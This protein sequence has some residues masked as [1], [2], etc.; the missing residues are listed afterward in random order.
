MATI[1]VRGVPT[2]DG[3]ELLAQIFQGT[4]STLG[5]ATFKIGEG[6]FISQAGGTT[7]PADPDDTTLG[8]SSKSDIEALGFGV[9]SLFFIQ[10]ALSPS[11]GIDLVINVSTPFTLEITMFLDF[12]EAND[13]GDASSPELFECGVFD[14]NGVM[15]AYGT[16]PRV[17]KDIS[18]TFTAL[19]KIAF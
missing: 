1:D 19:M 11:P 18:K 4:A 8:Y 14:N 10:K 12:G 15:L 5:L 9:N 17:E 13:Q 6:G 16:F 3:K 7:V 2:Q